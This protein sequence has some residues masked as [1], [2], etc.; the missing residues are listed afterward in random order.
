MLFVL[1]HSH[2]IARF[3]SQGAMSLKTAIFQILKI[4]EKL[5]IFRLC[6]FDNRFQKTFHVL[7]M[8][9]CDASE[10]DRFD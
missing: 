8:Q 10:F 4:V 7:N 9:I 6:I 1:F 2:N 3:A 5:E